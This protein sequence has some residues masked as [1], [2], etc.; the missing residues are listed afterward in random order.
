MLFIA[1]FLLCI[2]L[3]LRCW[4]Y[5]ANRTL[6]PAISFHEGLLILARG[7]QQ[8][9]MSLVLAN[10][11]VILLLTLRVWIGNPVSARWLAVLA[12]W[13]FIIGN[14]IA[15]ALNCIDIGYYRFGLHRAN[16]DLAFVLGDSLGSVSSLLIRY[17]PLMLG[18]IVLIFSLVWVA[19]FLPG[20]NRAIGGF[21]ASGGNRTPGKSR[22]TRSGR[23]N[24][25][26][27]IA[28][29]M[30]LILSTGLPG[31]PV[32]PATPLLSVEPQALPL[33]QNSFFTCLYSGF[34][35][36]GELKPVDYFPPG[37]L[38]SLVQTKHWLGRHDTARNL[39]KKNVII[40]ILESFSRCYIMPGDP[41]KAETPFF[42]SLLR[43]SLFFPHAFANG[44]SSNQ[45]IVSILGGLPALM[46]APFFY[47][48]YANTPLRSIGNILKEKG[49]TTSFLM[50]AGRDHF[51]FGKFAHMAGVDHGYWREDF[52]DDRYYDGNWGIFDEPF[53][54]FGARVLSEEPQPFL[55]VFFTISAHP[56]YTIPP[57]LRQR[58]D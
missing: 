36:S 33:A 3:L 54:Q 11:P 58:F 57:Q 49:Y 7:L 9:W 2:H 6:F 41:H 47:S 24:I 1:I 48:D 53:L 50:G 18:F 8:D 28:L 22:D 17:W 35:G 44:F 14:G 29:C 39:R 37:Q 21:R 55:G 5:I 16:L 51:G 56:P 34:R 32:I 38:D 31:R 10:L 26:L 30:L 23:A 40:F 25:L 20:G 13:F 19:G 52:H 42:D 4:F 27:Q 46:D 43:K 12:R 15:I 45:G